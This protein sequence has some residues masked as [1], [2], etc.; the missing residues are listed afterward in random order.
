MTLPVI[1]GILELTPETPAPDNAAPSPDAPVC[2]GVA[3]V[4]P[5]TISFTW[6]PFC[7]ATLGAGGEAKGFGGTS[8]PTLV[9]FAAGTA[10]APEWDPVTA[11]AV[12]PDAARPA[13]F[14]TGAIPGTLASFSGTAAIAAAGWAM[15]VAL[16]SDPMALGEVAEIGAWWLRLGDPVSVTWQGGPPAP[17]TVAGARVLLGQGAFLIMSLAA[18]PGE[19]GSR[20]DLILWP[21]EGGPRLQLAADIPDIFWLAYSCDSARGEA[22]V[23]LASFA[24]VLDR[25]ISATGTPLDLIPT[26]GALFLARRGIVQQISALAA[27]PA[28]PG[29]KPAMVVL[30]NAY[31]SVAGAWM[32]GLF[33]ATPDFTHIEGGTLAVQMAVA[34]WLPTLPDPYVAD[35]APWRELPPTRPTDTRLTARATWTG[36]DA[37]TLAFAGMLARYGGSQ[38]PRQ[39]RPD[40]PPDRHDVPWTDTQTTAGREP[41]DQAAAKR[42]QD[43]IL[44]EQRQRQRQDTGAGPFAEAVGR[45]NTAGAFL[46][47]VSTRKHQIGV[48]LIARGARGTTVSSDFTVEGM[49]FRLPLS[50]LRVFALPQIQWEPVRTRNTAE[51]ILNNGYFPTPLA[52]AT[53][54]GPT[55]IA[56]GSA[57]LVPAIPDLALDGTLEEF[58]GGQTTEAVTTL[59]FGLKALM[60]LRASG[61]AID[62][63]TLVQPSFAA[64][65][66]P[67]MDGATQLS[68]VAGAPANS[69]E[70][71][72]FAGLAVQIQNGVDLAS[73]ANLNLSVLGAMLG[74][75]GSVEALFNQEFS[76]VAPRV[77]VTRLDIC[78][79][80][81]STFSDWA[82]PLG[83]FAQAT[84]VQFEV[85]VGR[86]ALEI[87]KFA[88]VVLP[89]G[90]AT[91]TV[92]IERGTGAGVLRRDTGW[93]PAGS[94][95][96]DFRWASRDPVTG[97]VTPQ[98]S[99]YTVHPG[100]FQ[101]FYRVTGLRPTGEPALTLPAGGRVL[102]MRFD[103]LAQIEGL[104]GGRTRAQD[105]VGYLQLAPVGVPLSPFD[106]EALVERQGGGIGGRVDDRLVEG[107]FRLHALRVEAGTTRDGGTPVLVGCVRAGPVFGSNGSWSIGRT[108]GPSAPP[109]SPPGVEPVND[110]V[111]LIRTGR[112]GPADLDR[113]AMVL[114]D[115][116]GDLRIA[117]PRDLLAAAS[118]AMEYGVVQT[119]PTHSLFFRRPV[120]PAGTI[121]LRSDLPP[122]VADVFARIR[123]VSLFPQPEDCIA[124]T[125]SAYSMPI[126]AASGSLSLS[127]AVTSLANPRGDLRLSDSASVGVRLVYGGASLSLKIDASDWSFDLTGLT[128]W[129]DFEGMP[130]VSGQTMRIRGGSAQKP[131]VEDIV[132]L[133][134]G[135]LQNQLA[136]IPGFADRGGSPQGPVDLTATNLQW[137]GQIKTKTE[138]QFDLIGLLKLRV[139]AESQARGSTD[140]GTTEQYV[141]A[142]VGVELRG[143][144]PPTPSGFFVFGVQLEIGG[145]N[146]IAGP[147]RGQSRPTY[148]MKAS[149]GWGYGG[150]IGPFAAQVAVT[151]GPDVQ[152]ELPQWAVGGFLRIE[153]EVNLQ[154]VKITV[155]AE[156]TCLYMTKPTGH[157]VHFEGEVGLEADFGW[158]FS[159]SISV[160]VVEEQPA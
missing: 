32:S 7:A 33:G 61:P 56:S 138:K 69:A 120:L 15:P 50:R 112:A 157:F 155:Y 29:G 87:V 47:D 139:S 156:F 126:D 76:S 108:A 68:L 46:L 128:M 100:L 6:T 64:G 23:V 159:I 98:P 9:S 78:G 143:Q 58:Q 42:L 127:P 35:V 62:T 18:T 117:D 38:R 110:G 152:L 70:S 113:D 74:A 8:G 36:G 39:V 20:H 102:P 144:T 73:G 133:M 135:D 49:G 140:A 109:G 2:A 3:I 137:S 25:P 11:R 80:G 92:T 151:A 95:L 4:P 122:L 147:L 34:D 104:P 65:D 30:E 24:P 145:K 13:S 146:Y 5:A 1:G 37:P 114:I 17:A 132:T 75:E 99:P 106:V 57:R 105:V 44:R 77:P 83:A 118:P 125:N 12:L 107:G 81:A 142:T 41:L 148:E 124:L 141:G 52:S 14:D 60:V 129:N 154:I 67:A 84:K 91:R 55:L 79:Y 103:A 94:W 90:K 96:M 22:F 63:A 31:V 43:A 150:R 21:T 19:R 51:E 115:P 131:V 121:A 27:A 136:F 119:T 85:M 59:P 158:I 93:Q 10:A 53:D 149:I 160:S 123:S 54:G 71:P 134:N 153:S 26:S 48:Q 86:T 45:L 66:R 130:E 40:E 111:P 97:A 28:N 16:P 101:G 89:W 88:S 116:P 72:S 82:N